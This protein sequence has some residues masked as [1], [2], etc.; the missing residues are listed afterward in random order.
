MLVIIKS[1][2]FFVDVLV[3]TSKYFAFKSQVLQFFNDILTTGVNTY[4]SSWKESCS[5]SFSEQSTCL[6]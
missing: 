4:F 1:G 6:L 3:C 2:K 5:I